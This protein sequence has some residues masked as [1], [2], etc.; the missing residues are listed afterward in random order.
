[1]WIFVGKSESGNTGNT[2]SNRVTDDECVIT[3]ALTDED[4]SA[5]LGSRVWILVWG[6]IENCV[7]QRMLTAVKWQMLD[8]NGIEGRTDYTALT[9]RNI[10]TFW[11]MGNEPV[12]QMWG[13]TKTAQGVEFRTPLEKPLNQIIKVSHKRPKNLSSQR[14]TSTGKHRVP[15]MANTLALDDWQLTSLKLWM[16]Q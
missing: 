10:A 6:L 14:V 3:G 16:K 11:V 4:V 2:A 13:E 12:L 7:K 8:G 1:M 15:G 9:W 5:S